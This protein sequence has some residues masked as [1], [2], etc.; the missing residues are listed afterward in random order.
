MNMKLSKWERQQ[1]ESGMKDFSDILLAQKARELKEKQVTREETKGE[2]LEL[3][4]SD[5]V[6]I[7]NILCTVWLV[8]VW[9]ELT[10]FDMTLLLAIVPLLFGWLCLYTLY[11]NNDIR[12]RIKVA[13]WQHKQNR[14]MD[15]QLIQNGGRKPM[16]TKFATKSKNTKLEINPKQGERITNK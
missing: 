11:L 10:R 14:A 6:V 1:Y 4:N 2:P 3:D 13:V 15:K 7:V 5:R 12:G 8:K 9:I 16:F